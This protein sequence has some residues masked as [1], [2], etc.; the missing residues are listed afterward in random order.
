MKVPPIPFFAELFSN[1][2]IDSKTKLVCIEFITA[3]FPF[4]ALLFVKL[5]LLKI[6]YEGK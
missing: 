4:F 3:T 1:I 6:N 2:F 5:L